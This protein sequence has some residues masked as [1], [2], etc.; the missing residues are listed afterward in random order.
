[1]SNVAQGPGWW[2][3][4]NGMWHAPIAPEALAREKRRVMVGAVALVVALIAMVGIGIATYRSV[5][6]LDAKGACEH[7]INGGLTGVSSVQ[8]SKTAETTQVGSVSTVRGTVEVT[9]PSQGTI[10]LPYT[11]QASLSGS[12]WTILSVTGLN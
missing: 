10:T 8:F 11:C 1:M 4:P 7:Y 12:R 6:K 9:V 3:S 5:T 2:M